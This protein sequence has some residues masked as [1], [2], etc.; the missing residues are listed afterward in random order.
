MHTPSSAVVKEIIGPAGNDMTRL[1]PTVASFQILKEAKNDRQHMG[2]NG[3]A[4][5]SGGALNPSN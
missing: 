3:A 5:H 2:I 1:P 4:N